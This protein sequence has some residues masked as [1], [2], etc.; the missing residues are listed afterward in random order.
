M[1]DMLQKKVYST[2]FAGLCNRLEALP[3]CFAFQEYFGH[4]VL[5]DWPVPSEL[6]PGKVA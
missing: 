5:L 2:L 6:R 1:P 3:L 4:E